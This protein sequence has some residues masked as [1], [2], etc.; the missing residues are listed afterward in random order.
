MDKL[1]VGIL[2]AT[3]MVGQSYIT[4]LENHPWFEITFLAASERSAGK[5]YSEA[6][7]G[8]WHMQ[9]AIPG[10]VRE[11]NVFAVSDLESAKE[12]SFV[13]SA[14]DSNTAK[15]WEEKYAAAGIPIVS[16]ASTHRN[17]D[18]V[19][20]LIPEINH[21]HLSIIAVIGKR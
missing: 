21:Q 10:S 7:S 4:L 16:N 12:C 6:V 18:D 19:P 1:K 8:R 11:L 9:K 3:G 14:L 13:F 20:M 5:N 2:G 15:E 17:D